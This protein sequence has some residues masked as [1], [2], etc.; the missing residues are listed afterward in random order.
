MQVLFVYF[1]LDLSAECD[2]FRKQY[3]T[4]VDTLK[5]ADLYRYFVSEGIITFAEN[6][7]LTAENNPTKKVEALL[8]KISGPLESGLTGKSFYVMLEV[9]ASYGNMA[10]KELARNIN[11]TLGALKFNHG[12]ICIAV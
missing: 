2:V 5:T 12:K 10:T 3:G 6:E 9:M 1:V 7:E 11:D 8:R 4:L